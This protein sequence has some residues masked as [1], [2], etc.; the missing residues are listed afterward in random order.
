MGPAFPRSCQSDQIMPSSVWRMAVVINSWRNSLTGGRGKQEADFSPLL[1][2]VVKL[3]MVFCMATWK[4]P[5]TLVQQ[6]ATTLHRLL[7]SHGR[8]I[9]FSSFSSLISVFLTPSALK[10]SHPRNICTEAL[11]QSSRQLDLS[12]MGKEVL[13]LL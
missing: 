2:T 7:R 4:I 9:C 13:F 8:C 10:M 1:P 5:E 11:P 3:E 6:L 12:L